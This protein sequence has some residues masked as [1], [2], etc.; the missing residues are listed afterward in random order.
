MLGSSML[1]YKDSYS[2]KF[3]SVFRSRILHDE[4][5]RVRPGLRLE[6]E[7]NF[8]AKKFFPSKLVPKCQIAREMLPDILTH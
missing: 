2:K 6:K 7:S 8:A 5:Q 3:K 1:Q 4:A